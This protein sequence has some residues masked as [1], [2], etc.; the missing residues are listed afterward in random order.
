[1][2]V[3][4][5]QKFLSE[6]GV[7]SRRASEKLIL[8]GKVKVNGEVVTELG[9]KVDPLHDRVTVREKI[10]RPPP[11]G[12]LLFNKPRGVVSTLDDPQGRP[13]VADFITK[14]FKS[15]YPVGRL[16]YD[17]TGLL[18]LTNDGELAQHL[19][20]PRYG[21]KRVY[22]AKVSGRMAE[23]TA[24]KLQQG[25]RLDDG[26]ARALEIKL[27]EDGEDST[28]IEVVVGE[29]RNRLVRRMMEK[30][31]HPVNKLKRVAHG[32]FRLGKLKPGQVKKLSEREY[33]YFRRKVL[34]YKPEVTPPPAQSGS[35]EE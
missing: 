8:Q 31:H 16:D 33:E 14:H 2:S 4:R 22:H 26:L 34:E 13:T 10:V 24:R 17:S 15:Y 12:V 20:H 18:L 32:P 35:A 7:A 28:W 6:C 5:L 1:M 29:G 23:K 3:E 30:V 9:R 27:L 25:V 11:R 19:L 21:F